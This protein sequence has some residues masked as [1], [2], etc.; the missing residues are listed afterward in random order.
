[1]LRK[2]TILAIALLLAGSLEVEAKSIQI[3]MDVENDVP[4]LIGSGKPTL[5][6]SG[7]NHLVLSCNWMW[8]KTCFVLDNDGWTQVGPDYFHTA[9]SAPTNQYQEPDDEYP[10]ELL[11]VYEFIDLPSSGD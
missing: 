8:W 9:L 2:I 10:G 6:Q 1:M 7:A 4:I 3:E 5:R 11:D